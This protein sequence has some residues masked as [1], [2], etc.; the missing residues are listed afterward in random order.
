MRK[1]KSTVGHRLH[2]TTSGKVVDKDAPRSK[3]ILERDPL[4]R[5]T[6]DGWL[7]GIKRVGEQ[8]FVV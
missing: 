3:L 6:D 5:V 4:Q 1:T 7:G 8:F 2:V